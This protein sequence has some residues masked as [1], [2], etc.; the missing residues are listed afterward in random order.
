MSAMPRKAIPKGLRFE[1]AKTVHS[2]TEW[3]N[4]VLSWLED[5]RS[6]QHDR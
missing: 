2:W 4:D 1:H 3:K 6:C 5:A